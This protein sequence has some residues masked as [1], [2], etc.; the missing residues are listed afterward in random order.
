MFGS[1]ALGEYAFGESAEIAVAP[2]VIVDPPTTAVPIIA[3]E[4]QYM[5]IS[6]KKLDLIYAYV[7]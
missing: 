6:G 5:R 1:S 4:V 7:T 3:G 2:P